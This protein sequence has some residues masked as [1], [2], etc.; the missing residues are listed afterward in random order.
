[1]TALLQLDS[2]MLL[3]IQE[4][5][6]QEWL[7]PIMKLITH[8]GDAGIFWIVLTALLLLIPK[9]RKIGFL[10]FI[11]LLVNFLC[12]NVILKNFI[13]RPRPYTMIEGLELL[14]KEA[15]DFSF[16]SGHTAASFA[17][18]WI[19]LFKLPKKAGVPLFI[20]AALIGLSRLYIGIHY[21]TDV[22]GGFLLGSGVSLCVWKISSIYEAKKEA[23]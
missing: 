17:C 23:A 13:A 8:L 12:C 19:L 18:A 20:L 9:T 7:T 21:P 10:C 14:V 15:S 5:I 1:M 2:N 16:P 6:R 11:A 4:N 3:W 22:L